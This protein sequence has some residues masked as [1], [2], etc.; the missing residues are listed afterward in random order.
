VL[1]VVVADG[2]GAPRMEPAVVRQTGLTGEEL[3][4]QLL[5]RVKELQ[6]LLMAVI[7]RRVWL[8]W[9]LDDSGLVVRPGRLRR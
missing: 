2:F 6:E 5:Q 3:R 1:V 9:P 4:L 8:Q 7:F